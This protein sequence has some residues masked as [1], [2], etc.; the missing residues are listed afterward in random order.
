MSFEAQTIE[1]AF[2]R[3]YDSGGWWGLG[4][5]PGSSFHYNRPLL[6]YLAHFSAMNGV[7]SIVDY[8]CGDWQ[9]F[10]R[11]NFGSVAYTGY[12]IVSHV[13]RSNRQRY[14][15]SN[16]KFFEHPK[17]LSDLDGAD[18][19]FIK[20][21]FMH[22]PNELCIRILS[23]AL[24]RSRFVFVINDKTDPDIATN[25]E[26]GVG[27]YRPVDCGAS[28]FSFA[29]ATVLTYGTTFRRARNFRNLRGCI[30]GRRVQS[31]EKHVQLLIAEAGP[32]GR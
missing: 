18:L 14:G 30:V 8:G 23:V 12:D 24:E 13:V 21:V 3:I 31:G 17:Q 27:G 22:L 29:C 28:P 7:R 1:T 5:G 25:S 15:K 19:Y 20:D 32:Y 10:R 4:S 16:V 9:L 2:A 6:K 26:T 11:Y